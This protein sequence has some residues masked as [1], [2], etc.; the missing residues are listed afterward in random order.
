[1]ILSD[2][3]ALIAHTPEG[4]R[5]GGAPHLAIAAGEVGEL[6]LQQRLVLH[7]RFLLVHDPTPTGH[8]VLDQVLGQVVHRRDPTRLATLLVDQAHC[9]PAKMNYLVSAG[10]VRHEARGGVFTRH[11]HVPEPN[12]RNAVLLRL[13]DM[14]TGAAAPDPRTVAL[15]GIVHHSGLGA[16]LIPFP[17]H[18]AV[19]A[20]FGE[21]DPLGRV[22]LDVRAQARAAAVTTV[23]VAA[24]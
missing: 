15:A 14:L 6:L 22:V 5:Y 2:E 19:L 4:V 1:M 10:L 7:D 16:E 13:Q 9:Y 21:Q 8:P 11:L 12:L 17:D 20:H 24:S 23:V 3:L 18:R